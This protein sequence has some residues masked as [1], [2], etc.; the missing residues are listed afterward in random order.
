[1]SSLVCWSLQSREGTGLAL[2]IQSVRWGWGAALGQR[3]DFSLSCRN[4]AIHLWDSVEVYV[5][6]V[7]RGEEG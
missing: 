5:S 1:M 7:G 6:R 4:Q 3:C 2:T